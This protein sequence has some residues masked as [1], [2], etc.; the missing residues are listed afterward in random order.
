MA[1]VLPP[2]PPAGL[3]GPHG[4]VTWA[5]LVGDRVVGSVRLKHTAREGVLETGLW[6]TRD[7]RGKA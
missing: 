6:L 2:R 4:E 3:E 5:V 7:A 1:Q